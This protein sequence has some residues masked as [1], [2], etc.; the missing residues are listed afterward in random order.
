MRSR[1]LSGSIFSSPRSSHSYLLYKLVTVASFLVACAKVWWSSVTRLGAMPS[2]CPKHRPS[3]PF[4]V[5]FKTLYK[6]VFECSTDDMEVYSL[7]GHLLTAIF[8]ELKEKRDL[9]GKRLWNCAFKD[10]L[11]LFSFLGLTFCFLTNPSAER[12][13]FESPWKWISYEDFHLEQWFRSASQLHV[14]C[15]CKVSPIQS[16]EASLCLRRFGFVELRQPSEWHLIL[17]LLMYTIL[18]SWVSN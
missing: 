8:R 3:N 7:S 5:S 15:V 4:H 14:E 17:F 9:G 10:P 13:K 1:W 11:H 6:W 16:K 18:E 12:L 2:D